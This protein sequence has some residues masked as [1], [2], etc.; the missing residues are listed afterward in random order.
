MLLVNRTWKGYQ[1]LLKECRASSKICLSFQGWIR[2][3]N[4]SQQLIDRAERNQ[5]NKMRAD[6]KLVAP[7]RHRPFTLLSRCGAL[8]LALHVGVLL[9]FLDLS[10]EFILLHRG[11]APTS[12]PSAR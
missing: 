9:D 2:E 5:E 3:K 4:Y 10:F 11:T 8:Q 7:A 6:H 1:V 12:R